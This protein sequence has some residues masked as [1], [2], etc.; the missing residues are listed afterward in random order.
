[1]VE[2]KENQSGSETRHGGGVLRW[3]WKS[4]TDGTEPVARVVK[5]DPYTSG[6]VRGGHVYP[7]GSVLDF[8]SE[9]LLLVL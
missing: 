3:V 4:G 2:E 8:D 5:S 7:Q 6:L 9:L 1:M